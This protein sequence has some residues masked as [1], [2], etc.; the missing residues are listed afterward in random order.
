LKLTKKEVNIVIN[1]A[2][3]V[4]IGLLIAVCVL[5]F[6]ALSGSQA[7]TG[8]APGDDIGADTSYTDTGY[9]MVDTTDSGSDI[10]SDYG[11]GSF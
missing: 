10:G 3:A 9:D 6:G 11:S 1:T 5:A 7:D 8:Y 2:T 4:G